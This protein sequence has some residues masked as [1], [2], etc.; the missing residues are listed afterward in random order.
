MEVGSQLLAADLGQGDVC[1]IVL[2]SGQDA[3]TVLIATLLVGGIPLLVCPPTLVGGNLQLRDTL[4]RVLRRTRARVAVCLESLKPELSRLAGGATAILGLGT[5]TE[6]A[7]RHAVGSP[8]PRPDDIAMMQLTSGTTRAPR[9]CVWNHKAV[10]AAVDGM[11]AAMG[12]S[13]AD[14]CL[15][16]TPLYHDMGL[17]NNFLLCLVKGIPLVMLSPQAF[18]RHPA[19]WLRALSD[20]GATVSWSPNFGFAL[21]V[22]RADD[23]ELQGIRLDHVRALWNAAE[24]IHIETLDAFHR[25][26]GILGL[27]RDALKANFGCAENVG[28]ATFSAP[29]ETAQ[30]EHVDRRL[31]DERGIAQR[32]GAARAERVATVASVGRPCEGTIV[33]V[34]SPRGRPVP[35][36]HVGEICLDSPSRMV[37]YYKNVNE[38]RRAFRGGLLHTGD[39]G[40]LRNGELFWTGRLR[41]RI[42]IQGKKID[43]SA[44]ENVLASTPGLREGCFAAFGMPTEHGGTERFVLVSE[45]RF[46]PSLTHKDLAAAISRNCFLQLGVAP[47]DVVLVSP[48]TLAKTSSGKRRHR[49]F[50]KLYLAGGL[51]QARL[52]ADGSLAG[53]IE[54]ADPVP[55]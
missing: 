38:T 29:N 11:A 53:V 27:K 55:S 40:Y 44:F 39:V 26:F 52:G 13:S 2:P 43:P 48:G 17:V 21:T 42:T 1:V 47:S 23:I 10:L 51:E 50:R 45:V 41:E 32:L 36:G 49:F 54:R 37:C 25:R 31:L 24:C 6:G 19:L 4:R 7:G 22:R 12:F 16:W 35:D 9:I 18:V 15:N 33:H 14:V 34:L 20:T 3:A 46:P 8:C 5:K 28:G 30:Y